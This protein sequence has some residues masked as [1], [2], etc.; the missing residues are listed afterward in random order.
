MGAAALRLKR[1]M[2]LQSQLMRR[3]LLPILAGVSLAL[4]L[5]VAILFVRSRWMA[6]IWSHE[7]WDGTTERQVMLW[8]NSGRIAC[9]WERE[10]QDNAW[11]IANRNAAAKS[12]S[13]DHW[14]YDQEAF[15][16]RREDWYKPSWSTYSSASTPGGSSRAMASNTTIFLPVWPVLLLLAIA[17]A[18]WLRRF[19]SER[20]KKRE[21]LCLV[22]GYD[23][24]AHAPGQMC[25]ECGTPVP[26]DLVRK[27]TEQMP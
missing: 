26:A 10:R 1:E 2:L 6:D 23:L 5:A 4:W 18:V 15:E 13:M 14:S 7:H 8:F 17:P 12:G 22:C 3:R 19:R 27:P 11:W 24:R 9:Q 21:G 20:R 16:G 25:P